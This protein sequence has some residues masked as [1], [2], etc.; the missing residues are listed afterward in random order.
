MTKE[1]KSQLWSIIL[2]LPIK[3][4]EVSHYAATAEAFGLPNEEN[5]QCFPVALF[6]DLVEDGYIELL[7][8]AQKA[9]LNQEQVAAID[10][11]T[12]RPEE[13]YFDYIARL[14]TN[15]IARKVK[16]ADLTHNIKR[17]A[18]DLPTRWGLIRRYA[19]A[20]GIL[21]EAYGILTDQWKERKDKEE[22]KKMTFCDDERLVDALRIVRL[23]YDKAVTKHPEFPSGQAAVSIIAEEM[24]ELAKEFNDGLV[25]GESRSRALIEAA[26]VAVT[27]IR[28]I[29][30]LMGE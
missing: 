12:R 21:T 28:T 9:H 2:N 4:E 19:K 22:S 23:E 29:Q 6:H 13:R 18:D 26:H 1:R 14:K 27:A 30:M 11:I 16:L 25:T 20:Y 10:A 3:S 5:D 15:E 17:C 7:E 24:G 8:L